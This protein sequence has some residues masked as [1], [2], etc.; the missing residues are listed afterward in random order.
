[1]N[2]DTGS[3]Q[4]FTDIFSL[5][6]RALK[7]FSVGAWHQALAHPTNQIKMELFH[8]IYRELLKRKLIFDIAA[9]KPGRM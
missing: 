3:D 6:D 9:E 4:K 7:A 2:Q 8:A 5:S 1:M